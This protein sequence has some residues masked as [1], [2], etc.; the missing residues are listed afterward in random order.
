MTKKLRHTTSTTFVGSSIHKPFRRSYAILN[1][2]KQE[3]LKFSTLLTDPFVRFRLNTER[4]R[5]RPPTELTDRLPDASHEVVRTSDLTTSYPVLYP[6]ASAK[7]LL[8][9][10]PRAHT[11]EH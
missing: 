10:I 8:L 2:W 3:E 9:F 7:P 1:L 5:V 4:F 11:A 6:A